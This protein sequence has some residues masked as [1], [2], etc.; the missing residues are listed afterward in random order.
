MNTTLADGGSTEWSTLHC[1]KD[2]LTDFFGW[3]LQGILA[4]LAFTCLIGKYLHSGVYDKCS[5]TSWGAVASLHVSWDGPDG[6][7][8]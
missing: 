5:N 8:C 4:T 2:A 6:Q 3:F 7:I 1:S